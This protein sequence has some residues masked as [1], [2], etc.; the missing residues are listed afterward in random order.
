M[1]VRVQC[2]QTV[3]SLQPR[4]QTSFRIDL[5][6]FSRDAVETARHVDELSDD[7]KQNT[8]NVKLITS[9]IVYC[10]FSCSIDE[11]SRKRAKS[12]RED[13]TDTVFYYVNFS[14]I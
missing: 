4:Q 6:F 11:V 12:G 10:I 5:S 7:S 1:I 13:K 3:N 2:P 14:K 9:I 8:S